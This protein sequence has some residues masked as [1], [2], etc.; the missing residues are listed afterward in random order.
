ML[1]GN[2]SS[3]TLVNLVLK[4][5]TDGKNYDFFVKKCTSLYYLTNLKKV[6]LDTPISLDA[7]IFLISLL[8][9]LF[10]I[11]FVFGGSSFLGLPNF[12]PFSFA[13]LMPSDFL[14]FMFVL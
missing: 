10:K 12:I 9:Y 13:I 8:K 6:P 11:S 3:P 5:V 1:C 14:C 4:A 7:S 2:I